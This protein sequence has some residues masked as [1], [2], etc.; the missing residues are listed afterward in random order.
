MLTHFFVLL[1]KPVSPD[2]IALVQ[3]YANLSS[4][5]DRKREG[6]FPGC[7]NWFRRRAA[8]AAGEKRKTLL[9]LAPETSST[10]EHSLSA[11]PRAAAGRARARRAAASP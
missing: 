2:A 3:R 5:G 10:L 1:S 11:L 7:G 6:K 9:G 8:G 4:L